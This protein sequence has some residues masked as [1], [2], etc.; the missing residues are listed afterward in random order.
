MLQRG[1]IDALRKLLEPEPGVSSTKNFWF[2]NQQAS[3]GL[4]WWQGQTE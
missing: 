1:R 4:D 2:I 3:I